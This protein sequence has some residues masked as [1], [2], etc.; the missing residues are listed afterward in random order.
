VDLEWLAESRSLEIGEYRPELLPA[1]PGPALF[2][3][4]MGG[5]RAGNLPER[6]GGVELGH[7]QLYCIALVINRMARH[8]RG[9]MSS[10]SDV[11]GECIEI[12]SS[13]N[14]VSSGRIGAHVRYIIPM[15]R[16]ERDADRGEEWLVHLNMA[17]EGSAAC[18]ELCGWRS[19]SRPEA[20]AFNETSRR[21]AM[22]VSAL[23]AAYEGPV[24]RGLV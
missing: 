11:S 16:V 23:L 2:S 18:G 19:A 24:S 5:K 14:V 20:A 15:G 3:L 6:D 17:Q 8:A 9:R 22:S 7:L 1:F 10:A 21:I 12:R 13:V 4:T